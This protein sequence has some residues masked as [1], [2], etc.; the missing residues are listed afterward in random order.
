MPLPPTHPL[1]DST[2]HFRVRE[3]AH[4]KLPE[5]RW[6]EEMSLARRENRCEKTS[7]QHVNR[8]RGKGT[9]ICLLGIFGRG[10]HKWN[11]HSPL[12]SPTADFSGDR[13]TSL[14]RTE[15]TRMNLTEKSSPENRAFP[16][17]SLGD[18][19]VGPTE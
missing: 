14:I 12:F 16:N 13:Y 2:V 4:A 18:R 6:C 5:V 19:A 3:T 11:E 17:S 1:P 7:L 15:T 9:R 8:V 10:V